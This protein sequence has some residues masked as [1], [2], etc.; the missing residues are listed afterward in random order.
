M[1]RIPGEKHLYLNGKEITNLV[2]PNSVTTIGNDAFRNCSGLTSITIPDSVTLIGKS[3]FSGCGALISI[4]IPNSVTSIGSAVFSN[5]SSLKTVYCKPTTP[6]TG[7]CD[8]FDS[9][10]SGRKIYVPRQSVNVYKNAEGWR[11]YADSI[12]GYD[13]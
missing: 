8:M 3:A 12:V 5:C 7:G 1:H 2:I 10:A 9:N 4:T 13:F 11:D 6:P